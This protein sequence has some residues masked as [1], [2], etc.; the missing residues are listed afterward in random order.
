MIRFTIA[1]G[2]KICL[3]LLFLATPLSL[4][5]AQAPQAT[6]APHVKWIS[7]NTVWP[8]TETKSTSGDVSPDFTVSADC[9]F[10]ELPYPFWYYSSDYQYTVKPRCGDPEAKPFVSH[11]TYPYTGGGVVDM[12]V[13]CYHNG[14][15]DINAK[16]TVRVAGDSTH[17]SYTY[18]I[19]KN[20]TVNV[21]SFTITSTVPKNPSVLQWDPETSA[22][23][24]LS[25][26]FETATRDTI[27]S[28]FDVYTTDGLLIRRVTKTTPSDLGSVSCEWDGKNGL[29]EVMPRGVYLFRIE[30]SILNASS[31]SDVDFDKTNELYINDTR[32]TEVDQ[33]TEEEGEISHE[34]PASIN[35]TT[36]V[37]TPVETIIARTA[38]IMECSVYEKGLLAGQFGVAKELKAD[39]Y[40]PYSLEP[41]ATVPFTTNR[42]TK[43]GT[44]PFR[45]IAS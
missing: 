37:E 2:V 14:P 44:Y 40:G 5:S 9:V 43:P 3:A 17:A 27:R 25:Y 23:C 45:R 7:D 29:G 31:L 21:K 19:E 38:T 42:T 12:G 32:L 35:I 28:F 6:F 33:V 11:G 10:P 20:F 36:Q 15:H 30:G 16:L 39:C 18:V 41:T 22:P 8:R 13:H 4:V 26:S 24:P 1:W 34:R